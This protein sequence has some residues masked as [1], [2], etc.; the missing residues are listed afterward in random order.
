MVVIGTLKDNIAA[1]HSDF[2]LFIRG[3]KPLIGCVK[4]AS[5]PLLLG[6]I[7]ESN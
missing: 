5:P 3:R 1:V 4:S 7:G 2:P 6:E